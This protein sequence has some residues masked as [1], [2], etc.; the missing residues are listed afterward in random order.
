VRQ[1]S[2]AEDEPT[3]ISVLWA[4]GEFT[5]WKCD[6][7][8]ERWRLC[9]KGFQ[10]G[11]QVLDETQALVTRRFGQFLPVLAPMTIAQLN[12]SALHFEQEKASVRMSKYEISFALPG[13]SDPKPN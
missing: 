6:C 12:A 3:E 4:G 13:R 5:I 7:N 11:H 10:G 8:A 9:V 1:I 2:A